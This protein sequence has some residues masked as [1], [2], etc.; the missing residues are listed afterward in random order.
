MEPGDWED[1]VHYI[2]W[3]HSQGHYKN[4][5]SAWAVNH[6]PMFVFSIMGVLS[7]VFEFAAP[8]LFG[9]RKLRHSTVVF[10]IIFHLSIAVLMK[11]LIYFS[12]QMITVYILFVDPALI[13]R[14]LKRPEKEYIDEEPDQKQ[15][16]EAENQPDVYRD[17]LRQKNYNVASIVDRS[18]SGFLRFALPFSVAYGVLLFIAALLANQSNVLLYDGFGGWVVI[19]FC[20]LLSCGLLFAFVEAYL[21]R[22]ELSFGYGLQL[23]IQKLPYTLPAATLLTI[24]LMPIFWSPWGAVVPLIA[25]LFLLPSFAMALHKEIS[26]HRTFGESIW[27]MK[28]KIRPLIQLG[29]IVLAFYWLVDWFLQFTLSQTLFSFEVLRGKLKLQPEAFMPQVFFY[30]KFYIF[31]TLI[32]ISSVVVYLDLKKDDPKAVLNDQTDLP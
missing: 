12:L 27:L 26:F 17:F 14:F 32:F 29:L 19:S 5:I 9:W 24:L 21:S 18:I 28:G 13:R 7:L 25:L 2:L 15:T 31:S 11:D 1:K 16:K 10:G 3:T 23:C 4:Y 8:V 20:S 30:T 6:L 22:R